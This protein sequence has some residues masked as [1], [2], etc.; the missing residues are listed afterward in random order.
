MTAFETVFNDPSLTQA[1]SQRPDGH[2]KPNTSALR[3][4]GSAEKAAFLINGN[5]YFAEVSRTLRQARRTIWIVGWDFNPDIPLEPEKSDETLA[6]LL[7]ELTAANPELEIRILIWALGPV[8]SEKSLQVLRKKNFPRNARIDLRFDLQGAVRGCHHQKLVC[9]DDAVGFI[10]GIDLTSRRWDTKRHRARDRLR[11]DPEG[12]SYDPLHDVQAMVTGDAARL[13]GDI[14]R[15]R[16]EDATGE[17]HLPLAERAPFSWPDD[18][19]VSL[20]DIP[21]SFALTEPSTTARAGI[22]EGIASTLDIISRARRLLYIEAQYLASFRVADA[23]AARL[24]EEDG[25]EV[26]I[27]CTRSSH[28]L[29]EKLVMGGNRDR[30]IRVLKR[31]DRGNRLRVYFPV[32][33]GPTVPGP[34]APTTVDEVEVLIHSKLMIADD[35]LVRIGSSNLNNRSEGL[36]SECDI[37]FHAAT[38]E[39]RR[40]IAELRN[41]LLAEYLGTGTETF[42]AAYAQSGSVIDAIDAQNDGARG[43]R[44]FAVELSGSISPIRGTGFFDPARP[45]LPLHRLGLGALIRLL[46][47]PA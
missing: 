47:R 19:P 44:E 35:D 27:I 36:D 31:A 29:I 10:G 15:R 17:Q 43:L 24:Q 46:I 14:A 20:R 13:I 37:L 39:H 32:V 2:E 11:R 1:K 23:I 5:R 25:P 22:C 33:P 40:A 38:D 7:H 8:Y 28:G 42:A 9:I 3:L 21:V 41:R 6:D 4:D 16:W 18:L 30:V 34:T 45:F 26:V 12:V